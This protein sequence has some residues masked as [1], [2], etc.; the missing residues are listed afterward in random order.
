MPAIIQVV[1]DLVIE[2]AIEAPRVRPDR[3]GDL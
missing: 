3:A 2:V 1:H